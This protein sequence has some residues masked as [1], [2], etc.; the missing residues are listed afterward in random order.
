[1]FP[2]YMEDIF[3]QFLHICI[4]I[5][6]LNFSHLGS[7]IV[8][9]HCNLNLHLSN[10]YWCWILFMYLFIMCTFF[11]MKYFSIPFS[12]F[13]IGP[14]FFTIE[15]W[16]FLIYFRYQ[17]SFRYVV[18][19]FFLPICVFFFFFHPFSSVFYRAH[20]LFCFLSG[21]VCQSLLFWNRFWCQSKN[22]LPIYWRF[23]VVFFF[24]MFYNFTSY[25]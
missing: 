1:M 23:L 13:L 22:F 12:H 19:I 3:P 11:L 17:P 16:N 6:W 15:F 2:E 20:I 4:F 5:W 9:S 14:F 8:I 18:Y 21:P 7:H 10:S 24:L 25:I